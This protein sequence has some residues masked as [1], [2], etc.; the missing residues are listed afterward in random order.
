MTKEG[1]EVELPHVPPAV[2]AFLV[3][4]CLLSQLLGE[5]ALQG[6]TL[7]LSEAMVKFRLRLRMEGPL[8]VVVV[9]RV[10]QLLTHADIIAR[11][12]KENNPGPA[13][14][15]PTYSSPSHTNTISPSHT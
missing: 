8:D 1:C 6:A 14:Y 13:R 15:N 10:K 7:W 2:A 11:Y 12:T 9:I 5:S 4:I 3:S